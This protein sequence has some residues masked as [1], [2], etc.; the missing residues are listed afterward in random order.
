M[1]YLRE[2]NTR[3]WQTLAEAPQQ[4]NAR[5]ELESMALGLL[6]VIADQDFKGF[7]ALSAAV[8][9]PQLDNPINQ[10]S[11]D[12]SRQLREQLATLASKTGIQ[13][14]QALSLQLAMVIEGAAMTVRSQQDKESLQHAQSLVQTLIRAAT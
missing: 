9:F 13:Q 7:A 5:A 8:E 14:A 2:Q 11:Q 3:L 10:I 1:E 4:E 6:A 12:F